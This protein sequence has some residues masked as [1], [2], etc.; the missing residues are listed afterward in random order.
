MLRQ[1]IAR[2]SAAGV[3][4]AM[5][6]GGSLLSRARADGETTAVPRQE[7][8]KL[9]QADTD[10]L[11]RRLATA[12]RVLEY[13]KLDK[14][15]QRK[16]LEEVAVTLHGL[17]REQMNQ[18]IAKLDAAA[19]APDAAKSEVELEAA[20]ER[21]REILTALKAI[22]A[23]YDAVKTLDQAAQRL[24][25]VAKAQL[26]QHLHTARLIDTREAL[27]KQTR[28]PYQADALLQRKLGRPVAA[29]V[30]HQADEQ[31]DLHRDLRNL[32]KQASDL[33]PNLPPEQQ[34]RIKQAEVLAARKQ[35]PET[36]QQAAGNLAIKGN[37]NDNTVRWKQGN[38]LQRKAAEDLREL[39]RT[40]LMPTDKLA[41]L[42]EA[43][44]RLDQA[45][46][47][48]EDLRDEA[49]T[50][51]QTTDEQPPKGLEKQPGVNPNPKN[52]RIVFPDLKPLPTVSKPGVR[53]P[54]QRPLP[55]QLEDKVGQ[56]AREMTEKQIRLENEAEDTRDLLQ[57]HAKEAADK[58]APAEQAMRDAEKGLRQQEMARAAE[59]QEKATAALKEARKEVDR[60]LAAAAAEKK[61]QDPL[62]ALKK[63][64][65]TVEKVLQ[66][67]KDTRARTQ[68]AARPQQQYQLPLLAPKQQELTKR[69]EGLKDEPAAAKPETQAAL[70]K[71]AKAMDEAAKALEDRKGDNA[72]AKQGEAIK[73]L[74]QVKKDL[75]EKIAEIEKRRDDLAKLEEAGKKLGELAKEEGKVADQA[76]DL[77]KQ[78]DGQ[79]AKDLG[80]KQAQMTPQAKDIGKQIAQAAPEA[81]KKVEEG[82]KHME[83]AKG[84]LE[85]NKPNP[86]AKQA[87]TAAKALEEARQ[88]IAKAMEEKRGQEIADQAAMQPRERDP[89][90][91]AQQLAKAIEQA[92]KAADQARQAAQVGQKPE[93]RRPEH[94]A[95]LEELQRKIAERAARMNLNEAVPPAAEAAKALKQNDI[96]QALQRQE[97]ALAKLEEAARANPQQT[98]E[99]AKPGE[100]KAGEAKAAEAK[101]G[102]PKAGE[103][104]AGEPMPAQAKANETQPGEAKAGAPMPT[105]AKPNQAQAAEAK[106]GEPK[107][108]EAKAGEAKE[109]QAKAGE[110]KAGE[111][112]A[113]QAKAGP[114]K[115]GAPKAGAAKTGQARAGQPR[116]GAPK[117][118]QAKA[119]APKAGQQQAGA[120]KA[121]GQKAGPEQAAAKA[122]Q[123][124]PGDA[125]AG[126]Q[127]Q[128]GE[129]AGEAKAGEAKAGDAKGGDP[130]SGE[131][132]AGQA[133]GGEPKAAE[134]QAHD[135]QA[136]Q[137]KA[138]EAKGGMAKAGEGKGG[139]GQGQGKGQPDQAGAPTPTEARNPA[140]LAEAQK[141]VNEATQALMRSQEATKAAMAALGQ[142]KA[143][144]PQ[145]VQ[146]QLQQA[147]QQ[148]AQASQELGKGTPGPASESQQQAIGQMSQA[149]KAMNAALQAMGQPQAQPGQT[150]TAV[151]SA[152]K[153]GQE[154]GQQPGQDQGKGQEPGKGQGQGKGQEQAQAKGQGKGKGQKLGQSQE[155]NQ[156]KGTGNRT[157]DG[158]LANAKSDLQDIQGDVSF[159]GLP[160]RQRELIR[161]ALSGQLPP[162]YAAMIQQYYVNIAR[163]RPAAPPTAPPKR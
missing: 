51:Q 82:A 152:D 103:P 127:A 65:D 108:G 143:Q 137:G 106:E 134:A 85:E 101:P 161:Q 23:R 116:A 64:A 49:K 129:K 139:Q 133:K 111:P 104:K 98:L 102:E 50:Q 99:Q 53:Q 79:Q 20:Y 115:A 12:L 33:K 40:L 37:P 136:G 48:Q 34:E 113:A 66:D 84:A 80:A 30:Q 28:N 125:K 135:G 31:D 120:P 43:R 112:K 128:V 92:Q 52:P 93:V 70:D 153:A 162:E 58:I 10:H 39:A 78:P 144:A 26:E 122:G 62:A 57:P 22:L 75:G 155:K 71:A 121:G 27:I 74:E 151:A 131:A 32:L 123:T 76:R 67:Q 91:A 41:A 54:I 130:N 60:L 158:R 138:G 149:L 159:L 9:V 110:A 17:S 44:E 97:N 7:K 86:A 14:A 119:G 107:A 3:V 117:T 141:A 29:E 95:D 6:A 94:Q 2:L 21:H 105:E 45:I 16:M 81:A 157:P 19:V 96:A 154:Q 13:Y 73:A 100:A 59:S 118:G 42:K 38:E 47:K 11:V 25:K 77:A 24:D 89:L 147:G 109:G 5:L 145:A 148:L 1:H 35:I 88:A 56:A 8:Q 146:P 150:P 142:A 55:A 46:Q 124:P 132:A 69:A 140:Q 156:P 61:E 83:A 90:N 87:D 36:M 72:V 18:V 68:D 163:G 160:P 126:Q 114:A 4:V 15:A 63:A